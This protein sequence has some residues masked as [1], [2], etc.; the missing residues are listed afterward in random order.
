M[1]TQL[2]LKSFQPDRAPVLAR[3]PNGCPSRTFDAGGEGYLLLQ[4]LFKQAGDYQ[5]YTGR[6]CNSTVITLS[7][8]NLRKRLS[9]HIRLLCKPSWAKTTTRSLVR[10]F[11]LLQSAHSR[12]I[13]RPLLPKARERSCTALQL[14]VAVLVLLFHD[15]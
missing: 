15:E 4:R 10:T 9:W 12:L 2:A 1:Q 7:L 8:L 11:M 5:K 6:V 3:T 14:S 13:P